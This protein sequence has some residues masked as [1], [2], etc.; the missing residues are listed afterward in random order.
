MITRILDFEQRWADGVCLRV[1]VP[2]RLTFWSRIQALLWATA[3]IVCALNAD[4]ARAR[5]Y[6]GAAIGVSV[7]S[8]AAVLGAPRSLADVVTLLRAALVVAVV[9]APWWLDGR[10]WWTWSLL[11]LALA[12][13]LLDGAIARRFGGSPQGASLDMECDQFAVLAMSWLIVARGG[14][15]HALLL[16]AMRYV[17]VIVAWCKSVPA[18]DPKPVDGDNRR[19]RI[20]CAVVV[21]ALLL[22][23]MPSTSRHIANAFTA[24]AVALLAWSFASDWRHLFARR[25]DEGQA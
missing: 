5:G 15:E 22:S 19:G 7:A 3:L 20:V 11:A 4:V 18:D 1:V 24:A 16:P 10:P 9:C 23:L 2:A 14:G 25:L 12:A 6:L 8:L 17:F 13:D 21:V